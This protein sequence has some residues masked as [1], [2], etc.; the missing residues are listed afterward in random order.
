MKKIS[1]NERKKAG[2]I[3]CS[4]CKPEKINAIYRKTGFC[5]HKYD[6]AC[7]HHKCEL[8]PN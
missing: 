6:Y 8:L 4:Y 5:E 7:E 3:Y 1:N 2:N